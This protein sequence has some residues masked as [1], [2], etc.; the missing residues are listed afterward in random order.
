MAIPKFLRADFLERKE[1]YEFEIDLQVEF[2]ANNGSS[3][4]LKGH[5]ATITGKYTQSTPEKVARLTLQHAISAILDEIEKNRNL[6]V[7]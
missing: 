6:F 7:R 3:I 4:T 1:K 2:N 5:G